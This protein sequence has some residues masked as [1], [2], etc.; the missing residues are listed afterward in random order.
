MSFYRFGGKTPLG[1]HF[2]NLND[3]PKLDS[4]FST[5]LSDKL[6]KRLQEYNE[7]KKPP[8]IPYTKDPIVR[9]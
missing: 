9:V 3:V 8:V 6:K 7:S 5:I 2:Q 1:K 4:K